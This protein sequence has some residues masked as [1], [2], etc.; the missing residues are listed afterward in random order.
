MDKYT[1]ENIRQ[2]IENYLEV[3]KA[4]LP[5]EYQERI[6]D[7]NSLKKMEDIIK[8]PM[9]HYNLLNKSSDD[10]ENN[11]LAGTGDKTYDELNELEK[12][13]VDSSFIKDVSMEIEMNNGLIAYII[14]NQIEYED[15]YK[16]KSFLIKE[17]GRTEIYI[18][19]LENVSKINNIEVVKNQEEVIGFFLKDLAM[20][21]LMGL[22]LEIK[23]RYDEIGTIE[24]LESKIKETLKKSK[25]NYNELKKEALKIED[26]YDEHKKIPQDYK[27]ILNK[28]FLIDGSIEIKDNDED[29]YFLKVGEAKIVKNYKGKSEIKLFQEDL[30]NGLISINLEI[31][32]IKTIENKPVEEILKELEVGCNKK[33]DK[34]ENNNNFI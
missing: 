20:E 9:E 27:N 17:N 25:M 11:I 8:T 3:Y 24:E 5:Y 13:V 32:K 15:D 30:N 19:N 21:W 14:P 2:V 28:M 33:I 26:K 31:D 18:L 29:K 16:I 34:S 10:F 4:K 7:I 23:E 6:R 12:A 22:P 1:L